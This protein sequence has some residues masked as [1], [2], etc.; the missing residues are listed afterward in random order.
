[1]IKPTDGYVYFPYGATTAPYSP[2]NPHAGVDY[3]ARTGDNIYA[4]HSGKVVLSQDDLGPCGKAIDIEGG[5]YKSRLCHNSQR[6]VGV[7]VQVS[8]GQIVAK[9]G[10]S[11]NATG[12][13]CH[14]VLWVDGIRV[15]PVKYLTSNK[16][17]EMTPEVKA[18][19]DDIKKWVQRVDE[20]IEDL[21]K[22]VINLENKE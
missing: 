12:A 1:M 6:L 3:T 17:L 2:S 4:P 5:R 7:G 13:H 19:L 22:H 15:D 18:A 8:E 14:W 16:E 20:K 11:G 9:A 21:K 10:A